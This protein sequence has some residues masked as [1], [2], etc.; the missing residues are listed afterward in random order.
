MRTLIKETQ[1][2]IKNITFGEVFLLQKEEHLYEI[3]NNQISYLCKSIPEHMQNKAMFFMLNYSHINIGEQLDFYK[4][5]YK[6]VWTIIHAMAESGAAI[7]ELG[8]PEYGTAMCGQAMA[9]FMHSLDDHLNDGEILPS[10]LLLLLRSQAWMQFNK[11]IT[12]F[13]DTNDATDLAHLLIN[14]YYEGMYPDKEPASLDEY[15]DLFKKEISTW[16]I[17]PMLAAMKVFGNMEKVFEIKKAMGHFGVAWRLLDDIQDAEEDLTFGRHTAIYHS[18]SA[19]AKMLWD[20]E[21]QKK[22]GENTDADVHEEIFRELAAGN[23]VRDLAVRIVRKL[24]AAGE[25]AEALGMRGLA[26]QYKALGMPIENM[27]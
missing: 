25:A 26:M 6:P 1:H 11:A 21:K 4:N 27:L 23:I 17:M 22:A 20:A 10:H 5:F 18:I 3:L 12:E 9:L 8:K 13:A 14:E 16:Y 15:C 19:D 2:I 7:H 24:D